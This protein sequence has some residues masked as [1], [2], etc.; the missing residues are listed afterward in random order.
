MTDDESGGSPPWVPVLRD[1]ARLSGHELRNSLNALVVNLEVVR[2]RADSLESLRPFVAQAVEQSE[3]SVR[4]AEGAIALLNLV[5]DA[6]GNSGSLRIEYVEPRGIRIES[7]EVDAARTTR[8]LGPLS[9][10]SPLDAEKRASAV[11]LSIPEES[12]R[13][14]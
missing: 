9:A 11:I 13:K 12:R 2:G 10:R 8:A 14:P 3:E 5:V 6:V 7:T 4:L 1:V